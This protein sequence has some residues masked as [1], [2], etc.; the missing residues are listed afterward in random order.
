MSGL[1][2]AWTWVYHHV[3]GQVCMEQFGDE[4]CGDRFP[5][6]GAGIA[7]NVVVPTVLNLR[8][9]LLVGHRQPC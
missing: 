6:V 5:P 1:E 8:N 7:D 4:I 9:S 3:H 2:A